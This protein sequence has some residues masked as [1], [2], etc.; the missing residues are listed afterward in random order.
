M[1]EVA[2]AE[3][4]DGRDPNVLLLQW[5]FLNPDPGAFKAM[6]TYDIR[7]FVG[8]SAGSLD[9]RPVMTKGVGGWLK[10]H[11]GQF[12]LRSRLLKDWPQAGRGAAAQGAVLDKPGP[13]GSHHP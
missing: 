5:D 1:Y 13:Q 12:A 7:R 8:A 11:G 4:H 9:H 2:F 6:I 10:S 3:D